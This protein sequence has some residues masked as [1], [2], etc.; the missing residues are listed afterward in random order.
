MQIFI[1]YACEASQNGGVAFVNNCSKLN[2]NLLNHWR[3]DDIWTC[4]LSNLD[5]YSL[6]SANQEAPLLVMVDHCL[7]KNSYIHNF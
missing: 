7:K 1:I 5:L 3:A 2:I 4:R 6:N